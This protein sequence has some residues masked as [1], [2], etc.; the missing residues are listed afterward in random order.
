M[1][2]ALGS[3]PSGSNPLEVQVLSS[4]LVFSPTTCLQLQALSLAASLQCSAAVGYPVNGCPVNGCWVAGFYRV[5]SKG[6]CC[7]SIFFL[8]TKIDQPISVQRCDHRSYAPLFELGLQHFDH[9]SLQPL[10][11]R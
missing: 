3:G 5:D 4:V 6:Y 1:A 10:L 11:S 2:D 8:K 7:G 9:G